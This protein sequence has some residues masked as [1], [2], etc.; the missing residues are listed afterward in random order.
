MG[1]TFKL[2][3]RLMLFALV[4]ALLLAVVNAVT[5]DRI[6]QNDAAKVNAARAAVIGECVFEEA[7]FDIS[8]L[9]YVK[10]VY[11]A[12]DGETL[13]GYVYEIESKGYGGTV[14]FS[15][16]ISVSGEITGIE[17]SNHKETK[18]IGTDAQAGFLA[19]FIGRGADTDAMTIDAMAGATVSSN[20]IRNGVNEALANFN[21]N[22][23]GEEASEQ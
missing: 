15:V 10:G 16:G 19:A 14:Y 3:I 2:A 4:A 5:A 17:I 23:A 7:D 20:A 21:L 12:M 13:A 22:T 6:K 11:K 1:E 18:G 9:D 8:G